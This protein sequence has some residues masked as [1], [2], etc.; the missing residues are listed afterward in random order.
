[1]NICG[2][3]SV[4]TMGPAPPR[5]PISTKSQTRA[6][7]LSV[8]YDLS[9]L[10]TRQLLLER[11]G[12]DVVSAEGFAAAIDA[13]APDF[14]LVIMGHSIPRRDKRAIVAELRLHGCNARVLSLLRS[15]ERPIP[16]AAEAVHPDPQQV[17]DAVARLL[18]RDKP[19]TQEPALGAN[20]S[21]R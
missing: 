4:M 2:R 1:M 12:Y 9:L 19:K 18:S 10:E 20:V 21:E 15:N 13:C 5:S 11:C 16:E 3:I 8:S 17:L 6:R 7:I 14:D